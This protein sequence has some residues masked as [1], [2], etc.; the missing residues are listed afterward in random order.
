MSSPSTKSLRGRIRTAYAGGLVRGPVRVDL[1]NHRVVVIGLQGPSGYRQ[2]RA[3]VPR[4]PVCL[5]VDVPYTGLAG[6]VLAEYPFLEV[7]GLLVGRAFGLWV[8]KT[9]STLLVENVRRGLFPRGSPTEARPGVAPTSAGTRPPLV[10]RV[11]APADELGRFLR[12]TPYARVVA[13]PRGGPW[14]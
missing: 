10:L 7:A 1:T 9:V 14:A 11:P 13:G 4:E 3:A 6:P 8:D 5:L 12:G 2:W